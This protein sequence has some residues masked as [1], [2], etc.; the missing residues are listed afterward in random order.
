MAST[1]DARLVECAVLD[2]FSANV[3]LARGRIMDEYAQL[4]RLNGIAQDAIAHEVCACGDYRSQH[5]LGVGWCRLCAWNPAAP[6]EACGR[7][8]L[9]P[10]PPSRRLRTVDDMADYFRNRE[11]QEYD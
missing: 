10:P 11:P 5:V 7:F 8:R 2:R 1:I 6:G 4:D 3:R 9:Q